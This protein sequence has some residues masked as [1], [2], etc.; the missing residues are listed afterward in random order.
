MNFW[1]FFGCIILFSACKFSLGVK[2]VNLKE[3]EFSKLRKQLSALTFSGI[4][5]KICA[6]KAEAEILRSAFVCGYRMPQGTYT[7]F[8]HAMGHAG[9]PLIVMDEGAAVPDRLEASVDALFRR[10]Q[11]TGQRENDRPLIFAGHSRGAAVAALG[12]ATAKS[13]PHSIVLLD[14][15]DNTV[16]DLT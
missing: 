9:V 10:M 7:T 1:F 12:V 3:F 2:L 16:M 13:P 5:S 8:L 15:V 14:P 4:A 11:G 6:S